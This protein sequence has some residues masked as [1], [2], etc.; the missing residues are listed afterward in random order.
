MLAEICCD[1]FVTS[2]FGKADSHCNLQLFVKTGTLEKITKARTDRLVLS[3]QR[4]FFFYAKEKKCFIGYFTSWAL[5]SENKIPSSST[6]KNTFIFSPGYLSLNNLASHALLSYQLHMFHV[7]IQIFLWPVS[8]KY[9]DIFSNQLL[10]HVTCTC[11]CVLTLH[12][13]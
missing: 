2:L 13:L 12:R 11:E 6:K 9:F 7:I 10:I 1:H 5:Q 8:Q 4:S 3:M